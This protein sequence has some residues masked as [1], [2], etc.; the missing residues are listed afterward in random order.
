[1][2]YTKVLSTTMSIQDSAEEEMKR[3]TMKI[4]IESATMNLHNLSSTELKK[5]YKTKVA[6]SS[7]NNHGLG[8]DK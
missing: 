6:S 8:T 2:S 1:M 3:S 4:Q 7:S 5:L